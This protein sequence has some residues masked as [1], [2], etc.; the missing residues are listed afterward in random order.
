[1]AQATELR[2][3][4]EAV[5]HSAQADAGTRQDTVVGEFVVIASAHT[6]DEDGD[7]VT[8]VIV[9]PQDGPEH[10]IL[11]LVEHARIRM[12]ADILSAY[13]DG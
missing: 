2:E 8:Q 3:L 12:Q 5:V 9:I 11:G 6:F 13:D 10:R 1:M 4:I 7:P